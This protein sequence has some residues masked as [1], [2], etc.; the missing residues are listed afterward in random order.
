MAQRD[1]IELHHNSKYVTRGSFNHLDDCPPWLKKVF[2][3][4]ENPLGAFL[5]NVTPGGEIEVIITVKSVR[6]G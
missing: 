3:D 1:A 2:D 5:S 4:A 6:Y